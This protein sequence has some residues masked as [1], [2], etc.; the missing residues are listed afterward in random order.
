MEEVTTEIAR[1]EKEY[2]AEVLRLEIQRLKKKQKKVYNTL[3]KYSLQKRDGRGTTPTTLE[4]G[5]DKEACLEY[6][7]K[8]GL[9]DYPIMMSLKV[10]FNGKLESSQTVASSMLRYSIF[11]LDR[12]E[13][14]TSKAII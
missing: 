13:L 3:E 2:D 10:Y 1:L 5:L 6:T 11:D 14:Y 8:G 12:V 7:D 4:I 9:V